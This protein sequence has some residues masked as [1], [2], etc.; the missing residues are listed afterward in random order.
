MRRGIP[1]FIPA[2]VPR[3]SCRVSLATD[4]AKQVLHDIDTLTVP[5]TA[6]ARCKDAKSEPFLQVAAD[7]LFVPVSPSVS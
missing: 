4:R 2:A 1:G 3:G 7:P 6:A 5:G